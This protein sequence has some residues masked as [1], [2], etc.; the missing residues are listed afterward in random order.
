MRWVDI[1]GLKDMAWRA[2]MAIQKDGG[3][4]RVVRNSNDGRRNQPVF[5]NGGACT[6]ASKR[7]CA[8]FLDGYLNA[9]VD[10]QD[11]DR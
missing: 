8:I 6:V 3:G 1:Y 9:V 4:Y 11:R 10:Q 7:E 5:P 2:G